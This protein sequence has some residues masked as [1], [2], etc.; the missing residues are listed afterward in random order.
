[1]AKLTGPTQL[2]NIDTITV[3]SSAVTKIGTRAWDT[4]GNEYVYLQGTA[5]VAKGDW[6]VYDENYTTTRLTANEVGPVAVAGTAI[7]T[8]EYGWFQIHGIVQGNSDAVNA[9]SSLY[10][11]GTAGRV[12]DL[13]VDGDLVI[14]A[15]SM[16]AAVSNVATCYITYPHVS[17]DLG[18]STG[19]V[20]GPASSSDNAIVRWNGTAGDTIQNSGVI[21]DDSDNVTATATITVANTGL[22]ILDTNDS[23]DL[24]VRAGS[25]LTADRRFTVTTG[26]SD[27][28][29]NLAGSTTISTFGATLTDDAD[30]ATGRTTLGATTVGGN[31]FTLTNPSAV[32]YI[33]VNA[34][35]T[36]TARS[37]TQVVSDLSLVIGTNTQAWDNDL[38]DIAA[39]THTASA[40]IVSN[41]T[42]WTSQGTANVVRFINL[43]QK[44][45]G[46]LIY[47]PATSMSVGTAKAFFTVP[48]E[49]NSWVLIGA[50]AEVYGTAA[51]TAVII[52]V[53]KNGSSMFTTRLFIDP[54]E[55]GSDT[56]A[57]AAVVDTNNDDMATNDRIDY[58]IDQANAATKGLFVRLRFQQP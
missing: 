32:R 52:D 13:G 2:F 7:L 6:V 58:D 40:F 47:D 11:D 56:S 14:G 41:G 26:D 19:G 48:E 51:S 4:S 33:Q 22:H 36:V 45:V 12:D 24:I 23:H 53:N 43:H 50:H 15:Y 9:D 39:L 57:T 54:A 38:D 46:M 49:L 10:I 37:T 31:I 28:E 27:I 35:N 29:L 44:S 21:I 20:S 17:N 1:M 8:G 3:D 55:Q 42:D 25:N 34:D 18:G 16:T 30:A 5:S